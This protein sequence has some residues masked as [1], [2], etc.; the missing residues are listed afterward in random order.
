[1][2]SLKKLSW[3]LSG[4][5]LVGCAPVIAEPSEGVMA[6]TKKQ[7]ELG[8]NLLKQSSASDNCVVS[9]YSIHSA[10][11]LARLGAM[12]QT[13]KELDSVLV[14]N[15]LSDELLNFYTDLNSQVIRADDTFSVSLANS[16]WMSDLGSFLPSYLEKTK[17]AFSAE[18]RTI[19]FLQSEV[20]R[21]T[22]NSWVSEKTRSLIPELIPPGLITKD[23]I[24]ALVNA[25]YFKAPWATR[26]SKDIT[27][28]KDFW[29]GGTTSTKVPMMR[30]TTSMSYYQNSDWTGVVLP[31][32]LGRYAYVLAVPHEKRSTAKVV[33]GITPNLFRDIMNTTQRTRVELEMPR[34][35]IRQSQNLKNALTSLGVQ[36]PFTTDA[37]F[38]QMTA[39]EVFI[40][41]VQHESKVVLDEQGTE[42]A[43]A[44]AVLMTKRSA[45][46][47]EST[48]KEVRA[49]RPFA[50]A[51]VHVDS[52]AP[53]FVGVV[54]DP[55]AT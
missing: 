21:K 32:A 1:M 42:A 37:D 4:V 18:L 46:L 44:T 6:I 19:N 47:D 41:A 2:M 35:S 14:P 34:Y 5:L 30:L 40:D 27:S 24:A 20:A 49:D 22:I 10:L 39:L 7:F 48:P 28:D 12:G 26:F 43:A 36:R 16:I 31:Y 55:R 51:I 15:Q 25:L 11:M 33:E 17:R 13:A 38:K 52:E 29:I 8:I 23:T 50:F 53:L 3:V 54:G 45:I 9:P